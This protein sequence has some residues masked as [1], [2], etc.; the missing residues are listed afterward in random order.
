MEKVRRSDYKGYKNGTA[1][2]RR[3]PPWRWHCS[4]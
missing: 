1:I 3:Q 2:R 4:A